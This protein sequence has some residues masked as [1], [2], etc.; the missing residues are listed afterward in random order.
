MPGMKKPGAAFWATLVMVALVLYVLGI[1]PAASL[2]RSER[3]PEWMANSLY[4]AYSP[5]IYL[6]EKYA[7][8]PIQDALD[9]Y[10]NL[11]PKP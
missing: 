4:W 10:I 1:G 2:L 7:P 11:W 5:I 3:L 9:W 8:E 6:G